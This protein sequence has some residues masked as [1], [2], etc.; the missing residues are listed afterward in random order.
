M[1][2][3]L[4]LLIAP[5]VVRAVALVVGAVAA[6]AGPDRLSR[7]PTAAKPTAA[8]SVPRTTP[9]EPASAAAAAATMRAASQRTPPTPGAPP[10]GR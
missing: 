10:G 5:R 6:P 4:L 8:A 7:Q 2:G 9:E 1:A 3:V